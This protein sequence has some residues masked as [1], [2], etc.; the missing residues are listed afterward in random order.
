MTGFGFIASLLLIWAWLEP[1]KVG[2]WLARVKTGMTET[3]SKGRP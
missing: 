2:R 1:E 3:R